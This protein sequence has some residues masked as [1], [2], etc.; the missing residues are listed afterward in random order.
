MRL[1]QQHARVHGRPC[2]HVICSHI[3]T[4]QPIQVS[5]LTKQWAP[6]HEDDTNSLDPEVLAYC[7]PSKSR[8]CKLAKVA[9]ERD[10]APTVGLRENEAADRRQPSKGHDRCRCPSCVFIDSIECS[11]GFFPMNTFHMPLP[12]FQIMNTPPTS[13]LSVFNP[14]PTSPLPLPLVTMPPLSRDPL[15]D[16]HGN[17]LS[18]SL[19]FVEGCCPLPA[20]LPKPCPPT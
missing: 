8:R 9:P 1:L 2:G 13:R 15:H 16:M 7:H 18:P 6:Y 5:A 3:E 12:S 11:E 10:K 20:P 19:V 4:R 14:L 17:L